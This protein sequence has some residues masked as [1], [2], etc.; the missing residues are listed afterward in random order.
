MRTRVP[1]ATGKNA[2]YRAYLKDEMKPV[3]EK[4]QARTWLSPISFR[5]GLRPAK[6]GRC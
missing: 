4:A 5:N 2:E 1:I 3:L 6:F